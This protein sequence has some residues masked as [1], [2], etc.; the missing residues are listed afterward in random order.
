MNTKEIPLKSVSVSKEAQKASDDMHARF[1]LAMK[2]I[3]RGRGK[4]FEVV[5]TR[6]RLEGD[7]L[8]LFAEV[9][10]ISEVA[11]A[12]PTEHWGYNQ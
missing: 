1:S 12:V 8:I 6:A 4:R 9:P 5:A 7:Q 2:I 10:G 3:A 11:M